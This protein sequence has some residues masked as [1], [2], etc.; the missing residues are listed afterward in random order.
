MNQPDNFYEKEPEEIRQQIELTQASLSEKL[1]TLENGVKETV[2]DARKEVR[3]TVKRARRFLDIRHHV[4]KHPW[5][6]FGGAIGIGYG[7][8]SFLFSRDSRSAGLSTNGEYNLNGWE[9]PQTLKSHNGEMR[10]KV[11]PQNGYFKEV[12]NGLFDLGGLVAGEVLVSVGETLRQSLPAPYSEKVGKV[13]E[14]IAKS[15][16]TD[17]QSAAKD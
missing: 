1:E 4:R 6:A 13:I 16:E 9:S 5:V 10:S 8:S 17:K 11:R 2:K 15:F 14:K 3:N 7:L 12:R